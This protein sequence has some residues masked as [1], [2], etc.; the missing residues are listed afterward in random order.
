MAAPVCK[1]QC[2]RSRNPLSRTEP[3][4][5]ICENCLAFLLT[6]FARTDESVPVIAKLRF[7]A[8]ALNP[9]N[10]NEI[11]CA[12]AWVTRRFPVVSR[13]KRVCLTLTTIVCSSFFFLFFTQKF[14]S[15]AR[16]FTS[17]TF[18]RSRSQR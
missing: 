4:R 6:S 2:L 16:C 15:L 13:L 8:R 12:R 10:C 18:P 9:R 5:P 3:A 7:R 14:S 1:S 11:A 17:I